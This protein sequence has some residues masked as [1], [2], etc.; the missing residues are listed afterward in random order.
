MKSEVGLSD[1]FLSCMSFY[2]YFVVRAMMDRH[3][4][5]EKLP[6][7]E[8]DTDD[9]AGTSVKRS[10][11]TIEL[12]SGTS[13]KGLSHEEITERLENILLER[14]NSGSRLASFQL[15]QLY[16]EQVSLE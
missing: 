5:G 8:E 3:I 9:E 6:V 16:F 12:P 4:S 2:L 10:N 1:L 11:T 15:G 14:V 7:L 13:I